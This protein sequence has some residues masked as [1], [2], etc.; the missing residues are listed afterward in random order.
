[1]RLLARARKTTID[2]DSMARFFGA[3]LAVT[4]MPR[5]LAVVEV[6]LLFGVA[7]FQ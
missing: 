5:A 7:G 2:C 1:M 3:Q 4:S 6:N